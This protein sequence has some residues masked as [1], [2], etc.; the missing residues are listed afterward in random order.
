MLN[1]IDT[2][3]HLNSEELR[4]NAKEFLKRAYD[5]DVK[6][7]IIVGC[8]LDDSIEAVN[9]ANEFS[10]YASYASIYASIGIHPHD[11]KNYSN[12]PEEFF[13][14]VNNYRVIAIG[15]IGLD[16]YYDNSPREKQKEIFKIQLDFAQ[17]IKLPVILHIRDAMNDAMEILREYKNL[18][19][20]FHCYSGGLE[21]LDEILEMNNMIAVGGSLTWKNSN[22]LREVVKK[23]PVENL[24]F[25][26]DCPYMS[27]V[28]FRGKLNEPAYVRYVYEKAAELKNLPLSELAEKINGNVKSFFEIE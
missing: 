18:K 20:L 28:P 4:T 26:T 27:P 1:L 14:L 22:E 8:N 15:E 10:I 12:I 16:Y 19:F 5:N 3:C 11:S 25:E 17:K 6:K 9:M 23:I 2:H 7:M 24:L 13:K 21:Y